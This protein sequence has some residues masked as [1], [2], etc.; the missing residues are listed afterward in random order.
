M[1]RL[2]KE[3]RAAREFSD[4]RAE[5]SLSHMHPR[6]GEPSNGGPAVKPL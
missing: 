3:Y 4:Q 6:A 5:E 1:E 2:V